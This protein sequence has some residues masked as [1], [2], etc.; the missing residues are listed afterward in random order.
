MINFSVL[1]GWGVEGEAAWVSF[2]VKTLMAL[3][4]YGLHFLSHNVEKKKLFMR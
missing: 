3:L 1:K 4:F 2:P